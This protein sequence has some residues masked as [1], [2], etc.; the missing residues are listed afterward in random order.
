MIVVQDIFNKVQNELGSFYS[1]DAHA[2]NDIYKYIKSSLNYICNARD[3]G[4]RKKVYSFDYTAPE[5]VVIPV[6][7][8]T[9]YV[10]LD[11]VQQPLLSEEEAFL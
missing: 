4:F 1:T 3:W 11:G 7:L 10:L 5:K 2:E 8:K 6:N 9:Y